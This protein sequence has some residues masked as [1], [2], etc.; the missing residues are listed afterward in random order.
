MTFRERMR[1][2]W[3]CFGGFR[4]ILLVAYPL[5]LQSAGS[6]VMQFCDRKF[7]SNSSTEEMAAALPAGHLVISLAVFFVA[8]VG[9]SNPLTAQF[10]GAGRKEKCADVLW[11]AV[12]GALLCCVVM[13]AFMPFAGSFLLGLSLDGETFRH[14]RQYFLMLIP[15]QLALCLGVPFFAFYSGRGKTLPVSLI[16]VGAA[17]LN[18]LL[19]WLLIF[20][21]WGFPR[22]GILGAGLATSLSQTAGL[23]AA[24]LLALFGEDQ[25]EFPT[26]MRLKFDA[27]VFRKIFFVG[28]PSG[29][30]RLSNSLRFTAIIL[31]VGSL[32]EVALAATSIAL[33]IG[34]I[35]FL[36]VV[37]LA[38]SNM[39]L[40]GQA[41]G[42][43][44]QGAA[45]RITKRAWLSG[46]LYTTLALIAY[47]LFSQEVIA[48]FA[49]DAPRGETSFS[50]VSQEAWRILAIMGVWMIA[51]SG[52]YIFGSLLRAA[53]DTAAL[54]A[55]NLFSAWCV[56]IPGFALLALWLKPPVHWVWSYFIAVALTEMLLVVWRFRQGK[57]REIA[58]VRRKG[59]GRPGKKSPQDD[60][61]A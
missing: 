12:A 1:E 60:S 30:Q 14:A 23:A 44:E 21:H 19:D 55:I 9:F 29:F 40:S 26:R 46:L 5:L 4:D 20:G 48:L 42:R 10:F 47:L 25:K 28:G 54:F 49:P 51:D 45:V 52:R 35:S 6:V 37:S 15:G 13:A 27:D 22:M 34:A 58:L 18:I 57:W 16:N 50:I 11:T 17:F 3:S 33:S 7:L 53:G 36:P 8:T 59:G 38:G 41:L 43:R 24:V 56:G 32:G 2:E 31:L 39:I 61:A